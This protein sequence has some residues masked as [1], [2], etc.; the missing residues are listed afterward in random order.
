MD[1][2]MNIHPDMPCP[3][4]RENLKKIKDGQLSSLDYGWPPLSGRY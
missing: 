1:V 2:V 4:K 3:K